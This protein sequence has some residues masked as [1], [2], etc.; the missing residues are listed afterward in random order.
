MNLDV[1]IIEDEKSSQ[2]ILKHFL[3]EYTQ[4]VNILGVADGIQEG[5]ELL[6]TQSP[7]LI[8]LDIELSDGSGFEFLEQVKNR[9]FLLVFVTGYDQFGVKAIKQEAFDYILK[10][11]A[12]KEIT[13][14][15]EKAKQ[16]LTQ[17]NLLQDIESSTSSNIK[18][19]KE[20]KLALKSVSGTKIIDSMSVEYISVDEPYCRINL[21]D[22]STIMVQNSLKGLLPHLPDYL[23]R[24]HRSFIVN[25]YRVIRWD[26]GRGGYVEMES[27]IS[28]PTS[29]RL[30]KSFLEAMKLHTNQIQ[31]K[32]NKS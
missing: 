13:Q 1:I 7:N 16:K 32:N 8:F 27:G 30:K 20:G 31:K 10:P 2:K 15:V 18:N 3:S 17:I 23:F 26:K 29:Y 21:N 14:V 9:N 5:L 4:G 19:I 25:L 11:F 12:I 24:I 6:K 28:I 22:N